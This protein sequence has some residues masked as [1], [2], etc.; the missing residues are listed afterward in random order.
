MFAH[1]LRDESGVAAREVAD[2]GE[3]PGLE[4][5]AATLAAEFRAWA[6][7]PAGTP[8]VREWVMARWNGVGDSGYRGYVS[9]LLDREDIPTHGDHV[10]VVTD[11]LARLGRDARATGH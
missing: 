11:C 1:A 4:P 5:A 6:L 2:A 8:D 10:R 7:Q 3:L 9:R